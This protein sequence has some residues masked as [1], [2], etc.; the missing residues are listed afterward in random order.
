MQNEQPHR[1]PRVLRRS[2]RVELSLQPKKRRIP[3]FRIV[4]LPLLLVAGFASAIL[5]GT[6][7]L[8]LPW[9]SAQSTWTDPSVALFVSTSAVCVT[10]LVPVDT[11]THWSGFGEAVILVLIQFGGFGFMTSAALLFLLFGWRLGVRERGFLSQ[12]LDLS[13]M[14]GIVRFTRR[15]IAFTVIAELIGFVI[16]FVKF[17]TEE[18][19][20]TAVWWAVFHSVSAFNNAGFDVF[21]GAKSLEEHRDGVV[22]LTTA[23]LVV[24]GGLG[25]L[26]VEDIFEHRQRKLSLD[27]RLV[28]KTTLGLLVVGFVLFASLEWQNSLRGMEASDKLL[29]SFF[30]A[31]TP[32]TAGFNSVPVTEF[33]EETL[34]ITMFLMFV[35][36]ASGSTAGGIKVGTFAIVVLAALAA[37]RGMPEIEV[38]GRRIRRS[39]ADRALAVLLSSGALVLFAT[40]LLGILQG[41][42]LFLLLFETVSAFGTVGLSAAVTPDLNKGSLLLLSLVMFAGRLGPLTLVLALLQ[43]DRSPSRR[44]PEERVRI[45]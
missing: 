35:G 11:A 45:G 31:V 37:A 20:L 14:G 44:L 40:V 12:S 22:L 8:M 3:T 13:R 32:R 10:G 18:P 21:G 5:I 41:Q 27:T 23:A 15:A 29:Q 26:V 16:F 6:L 28:L 39:E 7:L 19:M 42:Q 1:Y 4:S 25:F 9:S 38:M 36:G 17:A 30:H 24:L 34:L 43:R 33:R 2:P